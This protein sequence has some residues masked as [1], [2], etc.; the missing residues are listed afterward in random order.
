VLDTG[1]GGTAR[2]TSWE[3]VGVVGRVKVQ[4][5]ADQEGQSP[6]IYVPLTQAPVPSVWLSVRTAGDP[7]SVA[8]AASAAIAEVDPSLP[9]TSVGTMA[10][11]VEGATLPAR[12]RMRLLVALALLAIVLAS[13]G[14]YSVRAY[15]IGERIPEIGIRMALGASPSE[16]R[17]LMLKEGAGVILGGVILGLAAAAALSRSLSTLL[18]GVQPLDPAVFASAALLMLLVGLLATE[19]PARRAAAVDPVKALNRL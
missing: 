18:F 5:L 19:L 13:V 3:I 2:R 8:R 15:T 14:V 7:L 6:E 1:I 4:T 17:R 12:F 9:V 10:D 11:V 16:I